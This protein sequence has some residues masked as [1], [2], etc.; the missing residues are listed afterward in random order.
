M[1]NQKDLSE[2]SDQEKIA[3]EGVGAGS[4]DRFEIFEQTEKAAEMPK[5][6]ED[7]QA[8]QKI[9]Q[10]LEVM[11]LDDG[12][13]PG[14]QSAAND[15]KALDDKKKLENL[16]QIAKNKGVIFAVNVAKKMNDPYLL[17]VFHDALV[18]NGYY[19]DFLK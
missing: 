13:K 2:A 1:N 7:R 6:D 3:K 18:K 4:K 10:Q 12:L 15:I 8:H 11:D 9:R 19:K 17:D 5:R 14:A 16:L